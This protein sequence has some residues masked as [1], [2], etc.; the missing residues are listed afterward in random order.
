MRRDGGGERGRERGRG[1]GREG[2]V[3]GEGGVR[4]G[5]TCKCSRC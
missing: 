3:D 2:D 5:K 4:D 1:V